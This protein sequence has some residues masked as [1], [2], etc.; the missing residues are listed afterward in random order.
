MLIFIADSRKT[1]R[2]NRIQ[3]SQ[4]LQELMF[5]FPAADGSSAL[6]PGGFVFFDGLE[7]GI[8]FHFGGST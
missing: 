8:K 2:R 4:P 6:Y 1:F 5:K 3:I 7:G